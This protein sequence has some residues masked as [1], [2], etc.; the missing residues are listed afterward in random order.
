MFFR[1]THPAMKR[2]VIQ[3][4]ARIRK[5][6]AKCFLGAPDYIRISDETGKFLEEFDL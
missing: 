2:S 6:I 1:K 5:A 3:D 4:A